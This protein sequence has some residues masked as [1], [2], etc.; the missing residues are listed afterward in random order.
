MTC[1]TPIFHSWR[2]LFQPHS[3]PFLKLMCSGTFFNSHLPSPQSYWLASP[4]LFVLL[5]KK[6]NLSLTPPRI[7][8]MMLLQSQP[9]LVPQLWKRYTSLRYTGVD[10]A[11][12][13]RKT[14]FRSTSATL[15]KLP[16]YALSMSQF[17]TQSTINVRDAG[18][19]HGQMSIIS[20]SVSRRRAS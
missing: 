8:T 11:T 18:Y 10:I 17:R 16:R 20:R 7:S 14:R 3:H 15:I 9:Y 12:P 1:T 5:V 2:E 13:S 19:L 6:A 4:P